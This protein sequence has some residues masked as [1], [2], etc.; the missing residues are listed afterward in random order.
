M[1]FEKAEPR[2]RELLP[3]EEVKKLWNQPQ[4]EGEV[5]DEKEDAVYERYKKMLIA[6]DHKNQEEQ[7]RKDFAEMEPIYGGGVNEPRRGEAEGVFERTVIASE[8]DK[9][10]QVENMEASLLE[11]KNDLIHVVGLKGDCE[12]EDDE[13]LRKARFEALE[14]AFTGLKVEDRFASFDSGE[15]QEIAKLYME[16]LEVK[17]FIEREGHINVE[18][19][20]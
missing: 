6:A 16:M 15:D 12:E 10:V 3:D 17:D 19:A 7:A 11:L 20:A 13:S 1:P 5:L 4:E 14:E 9:K 18:K 2:R 8:E